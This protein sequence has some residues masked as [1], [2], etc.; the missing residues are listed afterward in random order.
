MLSCGTLARGR[1]SLRER[2]VVAMVDELSSGDYAGLEDV[3]SLVVL[4]RHVLAGAFATAGMMARASRFTT[5][6]PWAGRT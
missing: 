6:S 5:A 4:T 2:L 1:V 3:L